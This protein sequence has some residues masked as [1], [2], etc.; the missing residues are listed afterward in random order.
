[1]SGKHGRKHGEAHA[2]TCIH[3][4]TYLS[5]VVHTLTNMLI[6]RNLIQ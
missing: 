2:G 5:Q 6:L 3:T 4:D 1:M